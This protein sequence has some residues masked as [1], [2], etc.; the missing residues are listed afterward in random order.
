MRPAFA[1][2]T[3]SPPKQWHFKALSLS[4]MMHIW[5]LHG[6]NEIQLWFQINSW[7]INTQSHYEYSFNSIK[8]CQQQFITRA[9]RIL[10]YSTDLRITLD[11][12]GVF[13]IKCRDNKKIKKITPTAYT[14][15]GCEKK[16][17]LFASRFQLTFWTHVNFHC[18]SFWKSTMAFLCAAGIAAITRQI[19]ALR[20]WISWR[21][22]RAPQIEITGLYIWWRNG[23]AFC[24]T[25]HRSGT[26]H[27]E[28]PVGECPILLENIKCRD[29]ATCKF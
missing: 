19:F 22:S 28:T 20:L 23:T 1:T 14:L 8:S 3:L 11:V 13:Q 24:H 2:N 5:Y 26:W 9:S 15:L 17:R 12:N 27:Q 6:I 29:V 18:N 16:Y 10:C 4:E 21:S 7:G 25:M